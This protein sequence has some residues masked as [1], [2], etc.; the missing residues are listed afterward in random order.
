M[1]IRPHPTTASQSIAQHN[2]AKRSSGSTQS[3]TRTR[4]SHI[5]APPQGAANPTSRSDAGLRLGTA[6]HRQHCGHTHIPPA[7]NT[8]Q[9][10]GLTRASIAD[11]GHTTPAYCVV[12]STRRSS[13]VA[14]R[15][16]ARVLTRVCSAMARRPG[17]AQAQPRRRPP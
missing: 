9:M 2:Q 1:T 17:P 3:H 16:C 13:G 4:R 12:P 15:A 14:P 6:A 10:P 7:Y 11:C 8:A 5:P